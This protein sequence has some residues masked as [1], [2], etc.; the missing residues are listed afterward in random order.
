MNKV[1]VGYDARVPLQY[2]VLAHSIVTTSSVP[3][4]VIPLILEQVDKVVHDN[5]HGRFNRKGLTYFTY[6][7]F[8][9]PYLNHY[10][11]WSLFLDSDMIVQDDI[12]KLFALADDRYTVMVVKN[13]QKFEWASAMLFNNAKCRHLT[14]EFVMNNKDLH[15]ISWAAPSEIGDLPPQ[16]NHLENVDGPKEHYSLIHYT[17]GVP[18]WDKTANTE[19]AGSWQ[20]EV[21]FMNSMP[22]NWEDLMGGSVH[23]KE[24]EIRK[25]QEGY[26]K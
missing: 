15:R 18:Y 4:A 1:W 3:I 8:L 2:N 13:Q 12:N 23:H 21:A 20:M 19:N 26:G 6:S 9:V 16:W 24:G 14:P 17:Q 25:G 11:G 10:E 5:G 7:R 22:E